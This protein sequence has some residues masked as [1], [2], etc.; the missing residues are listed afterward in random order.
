M[1]KQL[2]VTKK[3]E[4]EIKSFLVNRFSELE[5]MRRQFD[6]VIS[7]EIDLY[8]DIDKNMQDYN[9]TTK[10]GKHWWETSETIP[11]IYTIVQTMVARIIQI[12]FG[13]QNYLRIFVEDRDY[14][15]IEKELQLWLQYELDKVHL[16]RRARDF[17][18]E[19]LVERMQWLQLRPIFKGK[20]KKNVE[21]RV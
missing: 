19:S 7:E 20:E 17:I 8:N 2:K 12:F 18:E 21:G 9:N 6:N 13:H 5:L 4:K 16:K 14:K 11:Y 15:S 1:P 3:K 10:K